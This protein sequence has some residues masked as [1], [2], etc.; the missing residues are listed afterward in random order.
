MSDAR[1]FVVGTD[2]HEGRWV[3]GERIVRCRDCV[4]YE[5][6]STWEEMRECGMLETM[7]EPPGCKLHWHGPDGL[8]PDGSGVIYNTTPDGFCAWGET[9]EDCSDD[10][11]D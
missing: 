2:G 1:E 10:S 8:F 7:Y 9:E 3:T 4:H 6:E 11:T 5:P